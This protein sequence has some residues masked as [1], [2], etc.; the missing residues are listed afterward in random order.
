[1]FYF[2]INKLKLFDNRTQGLFSFRRDLA[3]I[4]IVSFVTTENTD[5]PDLELWVREN[6]PAK[7]QTLLANAVAAVLA[8]RILIPI[9]HIKDNQTITFGD[10]G[11]VIF[12]SAKI[13]D[14]FN[15]CF[16]AVK[17]EHAD[18]ELGQLLSSVTSDPQ[19]ATFSSNL[20]L[21]IAGATNPTFTA[22]VEV[23]KFTTGVIAKILTGKGDKQ[24]GVLYMS[25]D[26]QEHYPHG[27]RNSNGVPD[28]T[29]NMLVDYAVFGSEMSSTDM[30][31]SPRT[32]PVT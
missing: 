4:K 3:T 5:L 1:M 24:V 21:L 13:P 7:K 31:D 23:A 8:S 12:E 17:S 16:L 30:P 27:I 22:A 25:L 32:R 6:D 19:F 10:T 2:R 15:W 28:L 9:E 26:R 11:Y 20:G 18:R 29:G 14:N